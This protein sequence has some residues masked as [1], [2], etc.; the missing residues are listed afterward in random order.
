M[1]PLIHD[2]TFEMLF[3]SVQSGKTGRGEPV[4][5][6]LRSFS[7]H[8]FLTKRFHENRLFKIQASVALNPLISLFGR[9][10]ARSARISAD[11]ISILAFTLLFTP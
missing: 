10:V 6:L 2:L 7:R 9:L 5:T 11:I 3:Y 8:N 1:Q 4:L